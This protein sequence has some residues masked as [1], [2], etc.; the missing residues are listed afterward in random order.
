MLTETLRS[1]SSAARRLLKSWQ[2][3]VLLA[4]VYAALLAAVYFFMAIREASIGQVILTFGLALA[5]FVL[6]FLLHAIVVRGVARA[7]EHDKQDGVWSLAKGAAANCWKLIVI[8]LPLIAVAILIAYLLNRA[9]NYF[10]AGATAAGD[11]LD[12]MAGRRARGAASTPINWKVAIFSSLR[13]L[14]FGLFLPLMIIH[15]W[16]AAVRDGLWPAVRKI[17]SN[18]ARAFAPSSVLIYILGFL[19][20]AVLPYFLLFKTTPSS[21]A[22]LEISFLVARLATVFLLTLFGW[23]MTVW[24]LSLSSTPPASSPSRT[25]SPS[26]EPERKAA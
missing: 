12:P 24:A 19:V 22:W 23:V 5:A 13:Y 8:S 3:M 25:P 17:G 7:G 10:G 9:Q 2:A 11:M 6:F 15:L 4:L 21:K 1:I 18:L 16:L 26:V 20:F 14:S